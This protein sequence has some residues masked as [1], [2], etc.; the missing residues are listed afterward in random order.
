MKK[1][2]L[3]KKVYSVMRFIYRFGVMK[4]LLICMAM[5]ASAA[6]AEVEVKW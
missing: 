2:K 1:D 5:M 3:N 6:E 4:S